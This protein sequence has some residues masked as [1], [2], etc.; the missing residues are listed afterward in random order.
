MAVPS[1]VDDWF[2][3]K[4]WA[5][6][7]HQRAMIDRFRDRRS[8]LLIAPTGCGKTLAGFLPSLIDIHET[9]ARGLHTLYISPLK[10]LTYDIQRNLGSPIAEIGLAVRVESRTGDTPSHRRQR[11]RADPPHILLTTPESLMLMLSYAD[12]PELFGKLR[13]VVIDEVHSL[14]ASKRGDLIQLCLAQL[15]TL[16]PG[17]VRFGLSATVA[18]EAAHCAW[19]G[20]AARPAELLKAA[21]GAAATVR[22]LPTRQRVP[23]A[24]FMGKYAVPQIYQAI[25]AARTTL[26][27]VNTR[28]QAELMFRFLWDVNDD[29]LPIA[30]YHGSLD[31]E[32]RHRTEAMM[33]AGKLR[34]VVATSALELGI[35]WGDVD[36]VIQLG[37]PKG[38]SR[39][40]QRIGRSN[41][42]LGV[43]SEAFLVPSNRFEILECAAAI[44][45]VA[46]GV[47]DGETPG[48]GADD[49][50]AQFIMNLAC[51][52]PVAPEPIFRVVTDAY[53]FRDLD[54]DHFL[55][56]FRFVENG[57]YV[58]KA[59]ERYTRLAMLDD[60]A[61]VPVS[62]DTVRRHRQNIGVIVEAPRLKVKKLFKRGG[63]IIGEVEESF[64][65]HLTPGDSF[66]F[67]GETLEFVGVREMFLE[68]RASAA[69][70]A[71]VPAYA[72]GQMPLSTFLADGVRALLEA[73]SF[74]DMSEDMAEWIDLQRRI[75]RI[76]D[77]HHLLIES[78]PRRSVFYLVLYTFE[79]RPAN[80]TLGMLLTRRMEHLQLQPM[81]FTVTDYG[82]A[83]GSLRRV[84]EHHVAA[85][86]SAEV[87]D[88]ELEAWIMESPMLKR[89][90]RRIAVIAGLT[91]QQTL[92]TRKTMKQVTFS[93]DLIYDV[94]L[95]HEPGHV[96]LGMARKDAERELLDLG[97]LRGFLA[98]FRERVLFMA[99]SLPSPFAVPVILDVRTERVNGTGLDALLE[100]EA[101][102]VDAD[103]LM[104]EIRA[105]VA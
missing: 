9:R 23:T 53:G 91:E 37:A 51:S 45:A 66:A 43:P 46:I 34:A 11:Q 55:A 8:T 82:L 50:L 57:G 73:P 67:A 10:A 7:P 16:A 99:L 89:S 41:H 104:A 84:E 33:A 95:K 79:G 65:Q 78:F 17:M 5:M 102:E 6:L 64:A 48:P 38:V 103:A 94:L 85:L 101:N 74:V 81:S 60:G 72:G 100:Q 62:Q 15:A 4:G 3:A 63:R 52:A 32:K 36:L 25:R 54:Y 59:Y 2:A 1:Y 90:F 61:Y 24:G 47:Q 70:V 75:S 87:L 68:A 93:T 27:F 31:K 49:V 30:L 88:A 71:K 98:A 13:A 19:L 44:A 58:L 39:L 96:L 56:V 14:A 20:P 12:A 76:P 97:R 105:A 86:I 29:G 28:A 35:D 69:R 40:L 26:V 18:D 80:Q 21:A 42:R 83:I 77:R 22:L 92:G